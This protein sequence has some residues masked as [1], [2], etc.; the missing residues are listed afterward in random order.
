MRTSAS[1]HAKFVKGQTLN[2]SLII[3]G[4]V[5]TVRKGLGGRNRDVSYIAADLIATPH[6]LLQLHIVPKY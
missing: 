3:A 2:K 5:S 4:A 6:T 1:C